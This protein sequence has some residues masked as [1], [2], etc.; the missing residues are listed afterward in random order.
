MLT[1]WFCFSCSVLYIYRALLGGQAARDEPAVGDAPGGYRHLQDP[2]VAA[3]SL[4]QRLHVPERVCLEWR[5]LCVSPIASLFN[6]MQTPTTTTRTPT[7]RTPPPPTKQFGMVHACTI[8]P[9]RK[10]RHAPQ[11][12]KVNIFSKHNL[13]RLQAELPLLAS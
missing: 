2:V 8:F 1:I 5:C 9:R 6:M 11:Q 3:L 13:Q 12:T 7:T 4:K 10:R